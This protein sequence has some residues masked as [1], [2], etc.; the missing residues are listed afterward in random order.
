VVIRDGRS[1]RAEGF[2]LVGV[3]AAVAVGFAFVGDRGGG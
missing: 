1:T 3:Y 2:L